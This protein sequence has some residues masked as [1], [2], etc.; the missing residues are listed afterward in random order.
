MAP[1]FVAIS[2]SP[3]AIGVNC[4]GNIGFIIIYSECISFLIFVEANASLIV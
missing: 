2:L 1:D 3:I 4:Q